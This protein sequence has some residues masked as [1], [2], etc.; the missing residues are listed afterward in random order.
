MKKVFLTTCLLLIIN[1]GF[2]QTDSTNVVSYLTPNYDHIKRVMNDKQSPQYLPKLAK[3]V[4]DADTSIT[5]ED[6]IVLYYGQALKDSYDPYGQVEQLAKIR[7]ILKQ[8]DISKKDADKI[9][10]LCDD[11]IKDNP[12]EPRAYW[13]RYI[14][15]NILVKYHNGD[16]SLIDK[17][18]TQLRMILAA[19]QSTGNGASMETAMHVT[20]TAQEYFLLN[21]FDFEFDGQ[22]LVYDKQGHA[23]DQMNVKENPY[24]IESLYF[25]VDAII[26]TWSRVLNDE[27]KLSDKPVSEITVDLGTKFVL[28]MVKTSKKKSTFKIVSVEKVGDTILKNDPALFPDDIPEN[29]IIGYFCQTAFLSAGDGAHPCLITKKGNAA[30]NFQMETEI[31][32]SHSGEF[33]S[34]SNNGIIGTVKGIEMW[35]GPLSRIRISNIRV[36]K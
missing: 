14:G 32:Y 9:L 7:K 23:Y 1:L 26:R 4:E 8:K 5:I 30:I 18:D 13:Y 2:A 22:A 34:T 3:M 12:A 21:L 11:I 20:H 33:Q 28:E 17:A 29:Q 31:E 27:P 25:N 16:T 10:S 15:Y 35:S 24:G 36:M 6:L 19:I